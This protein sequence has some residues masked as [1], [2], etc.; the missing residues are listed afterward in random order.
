MFDSAAMRILL[1]DHTKFE[2]RALHAMC[3][4]DEFD[5]IIVDDGTPPLQV[6]KMR[7]RGVNVVVATM[8]RDPVET[9]AETE[10]FRE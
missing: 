10:Q 8:G 1:A 7:S 2:R 5:A 9:S 3:A 4:L 6:E